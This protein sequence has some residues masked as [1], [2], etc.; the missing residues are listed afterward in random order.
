MKTLK[1][2]LFRLVLIALVIAGGWASYNYV[3]SFAERQREVATATVERGDVVVRAYTR[4]ELQ[5]VRWTTLSAPN[6]RGTTQVTRLAPLGAY[7]EEGDL[8]AE[9][10]DAEVLTRVEE[11]ELGLE[12]TD[13]SIK[14]SEMELAIR[15]SE[16]EVELLQA[17]YTVR[18]AELEVQRNDLLADIEA[19]KNTLNLDEAQRRLEKLKSD[20]ESRRKQQEAE[21]AV[22]Q[23]ERNRAEIEL[24]RDRDRLNQ[25]RLLSPMSGLVAI[26]QQRTN[27]FFAGSEVPNIREGDELRPGMAVAD[28]LDLSE[29]ELSARVGE[30]DRANLSVGQEAIIRLDALAD[31]EIPGRIKSLSATATSDAYSNDPAKKF[32]VLFEIDMRALLEALDA[33]PEQIE[34]TLAQAEENRQRGVGRSGNSGSGGFGGDAMA[35]GGGQPGSE[36]MAAMMAAAQGGFTG[37]QDQGETAAR[38]TGARTGARTGGRGGT[39]S[40]TVDQ[41]LER[42]PEEQREQA[43]A[44]VDKVLNGRQLAELSN[45]ER[46]ALMQ[47]FLGSTGRGGAPGGTSEGRGG[48][49]SVA[50]EGRGGGTSSETA[51]ATAQRAANAT[52][53]APPGEGSHLDV[54]L[55]PGLLAD[56]EIIVETIPDAIHVPA[57]A[58]F[59]REGQ[60]I[61]FVQTDGRFEEREVALSTRSE[62]TM[63]ISDGLR[64]GEIIALA[65]PN[66][67]PG[68]EAEAQPAA[69]NPVNPTQA[70]PGGGMRMTMPPMGGMG[71]RGGGGGGRGR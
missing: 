13:E 60:P 56:V 15:A 11:A 57:Q 68:E 38:G 9:F 45:E 40:M 70:M 69:I 24:Q 71:G 55:R 35:A 58:V 42:L 34:Q 32:D 29:L 23:Q 51:Q 26:K 3:Q 63:V 66:A 46:R 16:D 43:R 65:N 61:V 1:K 17:R 50:S 22:Q 44:E 10:D 21:L 54:L 52:L 19:K 12:Q 39:A 37:G 62:A 30:V 36:Q 4:G 7:A 20:I 47:Q 28:I 59:E 8:I 2:I 31:K 53:P 41:L 18:R 5:A 67:R 27:F 48:E 6:L 49:P 14:R 33:T 25:V 64:E